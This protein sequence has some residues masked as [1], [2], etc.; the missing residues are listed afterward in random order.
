MEERAKELSD[1]IESLNKYKTLF[2][3]NQDCLNTVLNN[4]SKMGI[5]NSAYYHTI[6][7]RNYTKYRIKETEKKLR[8]LYK[9]QSDI[10]NNCEHEYI[11]DFDRE[12]Y[13]GNYD[14]YVCKKCGKVDYRK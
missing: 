11:L 2:Q 5:D 1:N 13:R 12:S 14:I 7:I 10:W 4:L 6:S 8:K 3:E 9:E